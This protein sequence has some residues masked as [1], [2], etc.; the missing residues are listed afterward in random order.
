MA[1][2]GATR[3]SNEGFA[4]FDRFSQKWAGYDVKDTFDR[5]AALEI[6]E[7]KPPAAGENGPAV[8]DHTPEPSGELHSLAPSH[9][10][11]KEQLA[12]G[13]RERDDQ[14]ALPRRELTVKAPPDPGTEPVFDPAELGK[15]PDPPQQ[16]IAIS[17]T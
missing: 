17:L 13:E 7:D 11:D 8:R 16:P 3:G 9:P 5:W 14:G 15:P 12:A 6:P 2:F 10:E 1:I 4:L